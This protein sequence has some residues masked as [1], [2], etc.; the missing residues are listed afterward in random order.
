MYP[1]VRSGSVERIVFV[2]GSHAKNLSQAASML[3]IDSYMIATGGWKITRKNND[4]LIPDLH[5][6]MSGLPIGTPIVLFCMD[7]SSF[8]AASEDGGMAPI[9]KCVEGDHSYH[10]KGALVVAP[11]RALQFAVDQ[12]K[13]VVDEFEDFDIFIISPVTRYAASPCCTSLEHVT[14][15]GDPDFLSTI[16][17]D[18]TKLKFQLRKK[19]QPAVV[20]D[21]IELACGTGCGR[22]KV[23]QTLR[24]GWALDPVHPNGH[25]YAK[26]AL[27]LIE[28]VANPASKQESRKRKRSDDS[29]SGSGSQVGGG[30]PRA[31]ARS[32]SSQ[33]R[34][35]EAVPHRNQPSSLYSQ[36]GPYRQEFQGFPT[37]FQQYRGRGN[38]G[39]VSSRGSAASGYGHPGGSGRGEGFQGFRGGFRGGF[40][41]RG[42]PRGRAGQRF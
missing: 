27:N 12:L 14:N 10:V 20:I 21:G 18:L 34:P 28:K 23:E 4:N 29:S 39:S 17:S 24:A 13:R 19:F 11:E 25:I 36:Y 42:S 33:E 32:D 9:S 35:R 40:G 15:F 5:E 38:A 1:A 22:E 2:G 26:M 41:N 37:G 16:I 31:R 8:L 6:L 30:L 3:G 7:N